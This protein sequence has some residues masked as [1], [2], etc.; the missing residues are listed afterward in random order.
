MAKFT[1]AQVSRDLARLYSGELTE[2]E[3]R[4]ISECMASCE[5][6][7][8]EFLRLSA[9]LSDPERLKTMPGLRVSWG[10]SASTGRKVWTYGRGYGVAAA[11]FLFLV[12]FATS[13]LFVPKGE[14][15]ETNNLGRYVT[16]V[17]EQKTIN[18]VDG[19]SLILNTG[20]QVY[21]D[22]A[23]SYRKVILER[24]EIY[25]DVVA[26]P[27]RPFSVDL[28]SHSV[29]VLGTSFNIYK[30]SDAFNVSVI[31][32]LVAIHKKDDPVSG[33]SPL[34][35]SSG[36]AR[37]RIESPDQNRLQSGWVAEFDASENSIVAYKP[38]NIER[39]SG[40]R[41]GV[42]RFEE[43][44]LY[45]VVQE[46]NRYS[47]KKILIEDKS[48]MDLEFYGSIRVD[49][50]FTAVKAFEEILPVKVIHHFDRVIIVG[51]Q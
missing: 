51:K 18:L 29:T 47:G 22:M 27:M 35:E 33:T 36:G 11:A 12:I 32:G 8:A 40:W 13:Y 25:L 28:E 41:T 20:T 49:Q 3:A 9:V 5:E 6:Y 23:E 14:D 21:V 48:V 44:P 16:R 38:Q 45:E 15:I 2:D 24:G 4:Q 19:S 17:G 43:A 34:I 10:E 31:E 7:Q 39:L 26:D 50:L 46:L 42:I 30:K 37:V 1:G